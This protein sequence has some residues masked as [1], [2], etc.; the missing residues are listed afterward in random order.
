MP[1]ALPDA[2]QTVLA[3]GITARGSGPGALF[4]NS[5]AAMAFSASM[6]ARSTLCRGSALLPASGYGPTGC[7]TRPSPRKKTRAT[8]HLPVALRADYA[9]LEQRARL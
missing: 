9:T 4:V 6:A 3:A 2:A 8:F 1:L 5:T 7:G